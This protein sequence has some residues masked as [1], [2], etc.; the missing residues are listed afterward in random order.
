MKIQYYIYIFRDV[1]TCPPNTL[2]TYHNNN[3]A[4]TTR[5]YNNL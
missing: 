4:T 1:Y 3:Y 2:Y 5:S